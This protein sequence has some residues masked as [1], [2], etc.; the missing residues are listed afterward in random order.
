[1]EYLQSELAKEDDEVLCDDFKH[2]FQL[3]SSD[4][5]E[6]AKEDFK[7]P[8]TTNQ[9]ATQNRNV[10]LDDLIETVLKQNLKQ[11]IADSVFNSFINFTKQLAAF[12]LEIMK[13]AR[14]MTPN[15]VFN[16]STQFVCD[17]FSQ[18]NSAYSAKRYLTEIN[19]SFRQK[20][21]R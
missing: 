16:T 17:K 15:D 13:D 6:D 3:G 18:Y 8:S 21:Y 20:N 14:I 10:F 4:Q 5:H 19:I 1:M 2:K 9:K 7:F 12:N 11:D